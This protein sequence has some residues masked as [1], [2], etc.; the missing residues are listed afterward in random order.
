MGELTQYLEENPLSPMRI[1]QE[2]KGV[3]LLGGD[4]YY[5]QTAADDNSGS[6]L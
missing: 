3:S 6:L 5:D 1:Q 2:M 4:T